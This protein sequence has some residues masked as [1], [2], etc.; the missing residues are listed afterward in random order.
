MNILRKLRDYIFSLEN[1]CLFCNYEILE[2]TKIDYICSNCLDKLIIREDFVKISEVDIFFYSLFKNRYLDLKINNYMNNKGYLYK[3]FSEIIISGINKNKEI[4][5]NIDYLSY[6][7]EQDNKK[8]GYDVNY[9]ICNE[10]G[11]R[12]NKKIINLGKEKIPNDKNILLIVLEY[13]N[14]EYAERIKLLRS[15]N[16]GRINII[17]LSYK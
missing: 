14:E 4:L 5:E 7:P 2:K 9:L 12:I 3:A 1:K 8:R 10:I 16:K 6:F 11:Y 13:S 17:S 15:N